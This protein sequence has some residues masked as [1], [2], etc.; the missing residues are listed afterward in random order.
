MKNSCAGIG[1]ETTILAFIGGLNRG[2]LLRHTLTREHD[3]RTITLNS[4][5]ATANAYATAD[6]DARGSLQ[7]V[8]VPNQPKK[9]NN[10][11]K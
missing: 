5:I 8:A 11:N 4:M 6:D 9:G 7:A 10:N 2:T 3:S 1:D